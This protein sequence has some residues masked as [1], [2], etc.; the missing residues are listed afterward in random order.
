[1]LSR[2]PNVVRH[3]AAQPNK[4]GDGVTVAQLAV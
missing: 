2:H 4:G 3:F 1:M